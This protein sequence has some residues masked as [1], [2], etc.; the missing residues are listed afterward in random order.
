MHFALS[1][2]N[3]PGAANKLFDEFVAAHDSS[4]K[5]LQTK[6]DITPEMLE[7]AWE[8]SSASE[9]DTL[10][11]SQLV[12][13]VHAHAASAIEKYMAWKL[14]KTETA[15]IFF[16]EVKDHGRVVSFKAKAENAVEPAKQMFCNSHK[17]SELCLV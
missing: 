1:A 16:K 5:D 3:T 11:A 8:E 17:N 2:P 6:L 4:E 9:D 13:L 7:L 15:H 12:E 14:L 10:T